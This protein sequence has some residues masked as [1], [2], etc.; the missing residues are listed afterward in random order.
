[1]TEENTYTCKECEAE[2]EIIHDTISEPDFCPFCSAKLVHDDSDVDN[3][4]CDED[5][6]DDGC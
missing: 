1:M 6:E 4:F 5:F 2:F 3:D